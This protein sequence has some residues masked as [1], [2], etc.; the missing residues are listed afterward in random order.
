MAGGAAKAEV[1]FAII[2]GGPG[3][4]AVAKALLNALPGSSVQVTGA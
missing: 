4:L 3:G 2:G 1:D